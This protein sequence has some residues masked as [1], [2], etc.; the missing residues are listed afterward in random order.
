LQSRLLS[1]EDSQLKLNKAKLELSNFFA[2][3]YI[4]LENSDE[5][6]PELDLEETI[7]ET[8]KTK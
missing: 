6:T 8:L 2:R 3:K 7:Q 4:P 5:L 1:L